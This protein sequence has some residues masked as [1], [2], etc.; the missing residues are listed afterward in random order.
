MAQGCLK[1]STIQTIV[2]CYA[3]IRLSSYT[4]K[5]NVPH[6]MQIIISNIKI[7]LRIYDYD[8]FKNVLL[9]IVTCIFGN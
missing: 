7:A 9:K 5:C 3:Q 4:H 8:R 6:I 1:N 2:H